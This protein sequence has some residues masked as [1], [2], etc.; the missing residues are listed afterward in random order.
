LASAVLV[1]TTCDLDAYV[2]AAL[3]AGARG[4]CSGPLRPPRCTTIRSVA[5]GDALLARSVTRP[6]WDG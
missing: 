5:S 1:V 4:S 3:Q 2:Y 6:P